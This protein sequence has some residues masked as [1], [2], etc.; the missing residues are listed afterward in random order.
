MATVTGRG[1]SVYAN[2]YSDL[3]QMSSAAVAGMC[4]QNEASADQAEYERSRAWIARE[5]GDVPH[6]TI[7][8]WRSA[9]GTRTPW[10]G[11]CIPVESLGRDA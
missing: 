11:D 1:V 3:A 8:G 7:T 2:E 9:A 6:E 10:H 5:L 4:A